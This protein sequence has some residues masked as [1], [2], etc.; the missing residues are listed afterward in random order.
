MRYLLAVRAVVLCSALIP[1][2][3]Y[4][5][6]PSNGAP[7]CTETGT[8]WISA[9]VSDGAGG[10][11]VAWQDTRNGS[12]D[13]YAQRI[14]GIG[15]VQ[16]AT[17]GVAVCTATGGQLKP[18]VVTDGS[19]G[20]IIAWQDQRAGAGED[21]VY[22]QR[23]NASGVA[24]WTADGV[25]LCTAAAL[26]GDV[27]SASD[28]TGGAFVVWTDTRGSSAQIYARRVNAAGAPQWTADGVPMCEYESGVPVIQQVGIGDAIM[29]WEDYRNFPGS[30]VYAQRVNATGSP[31]W[32]VNGIAL[33]NA[34]NYQTMLAI[35][36]DSAGG[37]IVAWKDPR[38]IFGSDIYAQRI[39]A[40][41]VPKWTADGI[42]MFLDSWAGERSAPTI[43][44]DGAGG[45]IIAWQDGFGIHDIYAE[46]IS[47][48]GASLWVTGS[49]TVCGATGHQSD[50]KAVSDGAGGAI[51]T[52]RDG[53]SDAGD[54]YVQR[55]SSSGARLWTN[56]GVAM[57]TAVQQ[58]EAPGLV[59]DGAGGALI[60]WADRRDHATTQVNMYAN[61]V[62][63]SGLV[64]TA[65][66]GASSAP[67]LTLRSNYPNPFTGSTQ[68]EI[69]LPAASDVAID[70]YDV[71]GRRVR[72]QALPR[73]DAGWYGVVFDG[74]DDSGRRL[75][76]G[77]Y[78]YRV[79]A[80][81]TTATRK[82]VITR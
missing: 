42:P 32:T 9:V 8:Q 69:G 77:V 55:I 64:P 79:S 48:A 23:M 40:A 5:L 63:A 73:Q 59:A 70:V 58:Q 17:N 72:S 30:D 21:D 29:A 35:A 4:A 51:V 43:V 50:A 49:V 56:N 54:V 65:V 15:V 61:R 53:R 12:D 74:R 1:V 52:W 2:T 37:A 16:W 68:L 19:G 20:A 11:I 13:I 82:V 10:V 45:A 38:E 3:S 33:C 36:G 14:N 75:A 34:A 78:F 39:D 28:G 76:S 24:Q 6:W 27:A 25:A 46:R 41:G 60:A 71:A 67:S 31:Q 57:C 47:G 81:G 62:G 18:S 7:V 26:Q 66:D 44:S 80:G 22:V